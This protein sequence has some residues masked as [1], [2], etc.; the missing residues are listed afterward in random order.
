M[1]YINSPSSTSEN[2]ALPLQGCFKV[3]MLV[4]IYMHDIE[5]A[6]AVDRSNVLGHIFHKAAA[7]VQFFKKNL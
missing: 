1:C 2:I 3:G 4:E 7:E 5:L 6:L